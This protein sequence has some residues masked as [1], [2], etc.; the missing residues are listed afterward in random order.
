MTLTNQVVMKSQLAQKDDSL[1][2]LFSFFNN[3]I[4]ILILKQMV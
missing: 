3:F 2:E 4:T 1:K